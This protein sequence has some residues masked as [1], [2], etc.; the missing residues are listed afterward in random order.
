MFHVE[1]T[2]W[3]GEHAYKPVSKVAKDQLTTEKSLQEQP[4]SKTPSC[5]IFVNYADLFP[6]R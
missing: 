1:T 3:E 6:K 5:D 4:S 2:V